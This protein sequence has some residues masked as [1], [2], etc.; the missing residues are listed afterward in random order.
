MNGTRVLAVAAMLVALGAFGCSS[1]AVSATIG[2]EEPMR[3]R[4]S[5]SGS[6]QARA[7]FIEGEP[8]LREGGPTTTLETPGDVVLPPGKVGKQVLGF[9][10]LDAVAV[11]LRF[12]DFGSGYWIVPTGAPDRTQTPPLVG[13]RAEIDV[14]YGL[15]PGLTKLRAF[16]IDDSGRAGPPTDAT[17]CLAPVI[18]DNLAA[19][20]PS[21]KPPAIVLSLSWDTNVDLDLRLVTPSGKVLGA[22]KPTTAIGDAGGSDAGASTVGR[23]EFD[24]TRGCSVDGR[25]RE[26][27]IWQGRP[28]P[29]KYRAYAS[30]F[31][32]CGLSSVRFLLDLYA[33]GEK[34]SPEAVTPQQR[35]PLGQGFLLAIDANGGATNGLFVA[36]F[37]LE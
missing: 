8:S 36:E 27:V 22:G 28:E 9:A 16:A 17:V 14:G 10:G 1:D 18:P 26:N 30:L 6:G 23:L 33:A 2:F 19:C 4:P 37:T 24:S 34:A 31:D 11:G 13:W 15:P 12:R 21:R 5:S 3:A 25:R 29:G 32:A 7:Q 35:I 20:D